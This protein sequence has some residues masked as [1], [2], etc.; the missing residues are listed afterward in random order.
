MSY[1]ADRDAWAEVL[2]SDRDA[3][4]TQSPRWVDAVCEAGPYVDDSRLVIAPD[5]R[6]LVLPLVRR[7]GVPDQVTARLSMPEGFGSGGILAEGG[8]LT[9][10]DVRAVT[11]AVGQGVLGPLLVRPNPRLDRQWT[12][13]AQWSVR[14]PSHAQWL[15]LDG[16]F[17]AVWQHRFHSSVRRAVRKAER[18]DVE[19]VRDTTGALMADFHL[20]YEQSVLRWA[21]QD[22]VPPAVAA[23]RAARLESQAKFRTVARLLGDACTTWVAYVHG[24]PAAGIVV[25]T[26]NRTASY[27]RG[28]MDL[29]LAG[30]VRAN[31]LLHATAIREACERDLRWYSFGI[32]PPPGSGLARFKA[33]LGAAAYYFSDY[34]LERIP[35]MRT[36]HGVR[37]VAFRGLKRLSRPRQ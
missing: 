31:D 30:P 14:R 10:A 16:G 35:A 34:L 29:D 6:R 4:A 21:R 13:A 19:V 7:R 20:L 37:R 17:D 12:G 32:S 18:S 23:A 3:L 1:S 22:G 5:G 36:L 15:D 11:D 26:Q 25:L 24:R 9:E 28:A 8:G 2:A 27:W 33:G